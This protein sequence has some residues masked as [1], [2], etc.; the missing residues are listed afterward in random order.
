MVFS[1][2]LFGL[3]LA[4]ALV[5]SFAFEAHG[6]M[7]RSINLIFSWNKALICSFRNFDQVISKLCL[8][9][10]KNRTQIT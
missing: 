5:L 2:S 9:G 7:I 6:M 8:Y 3:L 4:E 10:T 1:K